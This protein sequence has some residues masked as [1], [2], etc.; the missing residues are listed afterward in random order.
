MNTYEEYRIEKID[1]IS[2]SSEKDID[3]KMKKNNRIKKK[4]GNLDE[5]NKK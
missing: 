4:G 2:Q 5:Y 1:L 3:T